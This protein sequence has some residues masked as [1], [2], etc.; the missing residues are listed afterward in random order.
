MANP[1]IVDCPEGEWTSVATNVTTGQIKKIG[2]KPNLY[3]ETYRMTGNA[4]PTSQTEGAPAFQISDSEQ[5]SATAGIDVY[6]M[7]VGADGRVRV[8]L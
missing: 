3:L 1:V 7:A 4:A 5:I 6:I 8:D 2:K